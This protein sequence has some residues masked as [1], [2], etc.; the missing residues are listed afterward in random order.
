V[1]VTLLSGSLSATDNAGLL[2]GTNAALIGQELVYFRDATLTGS[3]TYRLS[4]LL[5]ARQG[6]EW[7]M[8]S[9]VSG[10]TF[11]LL[12][13]AS[14]YKLPLQI[15]DLGTTLQ[16]MPTTLGQV[17]N[18]ST[19][20]A[21]TV[22]EAC[23]R[24]LA[25]SAVTAISGSTADPND[26]TLAWIRRARINAAWLNGTDVPLDE[27]T[28]SYRVQVLNG[29]SVVRTT[30]V[31]AAQSW[32]YPAVSISADGFSSGQTISFNVA[33]NSDQGV[34]GHAGSASIQR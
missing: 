15:A 22:N 33:Q 20:V 31:T 17:S 6:T 21:D 16:F 9:H 25:P 12:S 7:A 26:I 5:R 29:S 1:T 30:T 28:E 34:L 18:T 3:Y 13:A 4:G 19:A 32:I 11:V 27:S 14:L 24:P 2:A 10:E 23:V 8:A